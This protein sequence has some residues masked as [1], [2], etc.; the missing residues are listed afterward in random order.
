MAFSPLQVI[1]AGNIASLASL[2]TGSYTLT[3]G[4]RVQLVV[5]YAGGSDTTTTMTDTNGNTWAKAATGHASSSGM[6]FRP[7]ECKSVT[8]GGATAITVNWSGAVTQRGLAG[9]EVSGLDSSAAIQTNAQQT[10]VNPGTGTD[11]ITSGSITPTSQPAMVFGFTQDQGNSDPISVGTGFT[12]YACPN[13]SI[14]N[15][16]SKTVVQQKRVTATTATASTATSTFGATHTYVAV[17]IVVSE[18]A[19]AAATQLLTMTN[20]QAGF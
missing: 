3:A 12:Q 18:A 7:F 4:S 19:A 9:L 20:N 10:Q 5:C 13:C 14:V 15:G 1:D 17:G 8:V 2:A 6:Y 11:A 16:S